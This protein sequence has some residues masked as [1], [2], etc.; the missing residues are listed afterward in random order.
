MLSAAAWVGCCDLCA[1]LFVEFGIAQVATWW[2]LK[3]GRLW[4]SG[5]V[6]HGRS[7]VRGV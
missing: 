3:R 2:L 7:I 1:E 6:A 4:G 5:L